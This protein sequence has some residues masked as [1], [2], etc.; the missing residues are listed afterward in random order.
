MN[1][2]FF[3]T[4]AH[5]TD[6][7]YSDM[8]EIIE[9]AAKENVKYIINSGTSGKDNEKVLKLALENDN[10]F[11]TLGIHPGEVL[12]YNLEDIDYIEKNINHKKVLAI[13]EIGLDYHYHQDQKEIQIKLFEL[14][15][16]LAEKYNMPVVIHSR[17]AT[18][19]T[20]NILKKYKVTGV[21]HS[22]SGSFETAKEYIAM[23]FCLG[24]NGVVT[25]KNS[26]MKEYITQIGLDNIILETDCPFL[27]PEPFRGQKNQPAYIKYIGEY[28]SHLYDL[29][30]N[31]IANVT[32]Q[33]VHRI[34][35]K[36]NKL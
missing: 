2:Y 36:I 28:L 4:H 31:T 10:M 17:E 29:P 14:Q 22:F 35:D 20:I 5:V 18:L 11:C 16:K 21:I 32:T 15:L 27:T 3:D 12:N 6:E 33:N 23:D 8:H 30:L 1:S 34:F 13:G 25:F 9:S 26:K 7:Y 24:I 19:D